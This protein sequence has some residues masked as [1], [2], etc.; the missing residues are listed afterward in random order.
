M[1]A[2]A[3]LQPLHSNDCIPGNETDNRKDEGADVIFFDSKNIY[4]DAKVENQPQRVTDCDVTPLKKCLKSTKLKKRIPS[5]VFELP[6]TSSSPSSS[7]MG[8][9][10][11]G[12]GVACRRRNPKLQIRRSGGAI[13]A[14]G[15]PLG[16]SFA[17]VIAQVPFF[18]SLLAFLTCIIVY[19]VSFVHL[20]VFC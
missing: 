6:S 8:S 5:D 4:S 2:P 10:H 17:A 11:K 12:A 1:D 18:I 9:S 19:D 3:S 7:S 20:D 14:I 16:M 15:L 13:A